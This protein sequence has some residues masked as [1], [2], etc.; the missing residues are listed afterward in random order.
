VRVAA[1]AWPRWRTCALLCALFAP[2]LVGCGVSEWEQREA[3]RL[4]RKALTF[5]Q[6]PSSGKLKAIVR[7]NCTGFERSTF[8]SRSRYLELGSV[9]ERDERGRWQDLDLGLSGNI[10]GPVSGIGLLIS[11]AHG[12]VALGA[13]AY[14]IPSDL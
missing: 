6:G 4:V 9:F 11:G 8:C 12:F 10:R 14:R 2:I 7:I 5:D 1:K 3:R 13:T